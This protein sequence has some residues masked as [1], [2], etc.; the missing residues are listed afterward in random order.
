MKL[1]YGLRQAKMSQNREFLINSY[2][3]MK[4]KTKKTLLR[5]YTGVSKFL[6]YDLYG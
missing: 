6:H 3:K 1:I 4:A 2:K 5:F